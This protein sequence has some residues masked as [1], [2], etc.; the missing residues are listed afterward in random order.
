MDKFKSLAEEYGLWLLE[1]S[2]HAPGGRF[3]DSNGN[4]QKI[5]GMVNLLI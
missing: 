3:Y 1:D 5:V 4:F 2:C